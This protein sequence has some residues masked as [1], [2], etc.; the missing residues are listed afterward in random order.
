MPDHIEEYLRRIID[1]PDINQWDG[2]YTHL[3]VKDPIRMSMRLLD[4]RGGRDEHDAEDVVAQGGWLVISGASGMGKTT[5]LKWLTFVYAKKYQEDAERLIPLYVDLAPFRSGEFYNHAL[6]YAKKKGLIADDFKGLLKSGK[7]AIFLDGLDLLRGSEDFDPVYEIQNFMF[8]FPRCEFVLSARPGFFEGFKSDCK[9][10]EL[11][12]LSDPKIKEYIG[13][14]LGDGAIAG[15]LINRIYDPTNKR[16]K[17]LCKNPLMLHR[18]IELQKY[19]R[20]ASDRAGI[21]Q[22][23]FEGLIT[24]YQKKGKTLS[25]NEQLMRDVLK[26]LAFSMQKGNTVRLDYGSALDVA[27]SCTSPKRYISVSAEQVLE[28][29]FKL[30]LLH[31]DGDEVRF[32]FHQ[33]FQ[34][35]FAAVK[36]KDIFEQGYDI[37]ESFSQPKWKDTLVFLSEITE[38]PDELFDDVVGASKVFLAAKLTVENLCALL[39]DKVDSRYDLEKEMAL[40][41]FAYAGD[42]AADVPM[43]VF[44]SEDEGMI[45]NVADALKNIDERSVELLEDA[46]HNNDPDVRK[47]VAWTLVNIG[48]GK[49]VELLLNALHDDNPEVRKDVA[50]ALGIIR[51]ERAV[52]PLVDVLDANNPV[53]R[54]VEALELGII[55]DGMAVEELVNMMER[56]TDPLV[57]KDVAWALGIIRDER[58]VEP[59]ARVLRTD[60]DP[61]VRVVAL[62]ALKEIGDD[63]AVEPFIDAIYNDDHPVVRIAAAWALDESGDER[64]AKPLMDVQDDTDSLVRN[65]VALVLGKTVGRLGKLKLLLRALKSSDPTMRIAAAWILGEVGDEKVV[66][67]LVYVLRHD[68]NPLVQKGV[69]WALGKIGDERAA[70]P[71]IEVLY[72]NDS[73]MVRESVA[74]ALGKVG[75]KRAVEP[76]IDALQD[77]RPMVRLIPVSELKSLCRSI[78]KEK[79]KAL[80]ESDNNDV[81]SAAFEILHSIELKEQ[82]KR[83]IFKELKYL[84]RWDDIPGK[85]NNRLLSYLRE[86]RGI[87]WAERAEIRKSNDTTI[88]IFRDGNSAEIRINKTGKKATLELGD[89]G[90]C[91]MNA[92]K[93]KVES[94]YTTPSGVMDAEKMRTDPHLG[95]LVDRLR[96]VPDNSVVVDYGCGRGAFLG[97]MKTL[98]E[99]IRGIH[100]IGVDISR[101][102]R[103]LTR[104]FAE[105]S[106][107]GD[108]LKSCHCMKPDKFFNEN[109]DV[110]HAFFSHVLHEIHLKYLPEILYHLLSKVKVGSRITFLEQRILVEPESDFVTWDADDFDELFSGFAKVSSRL[111]QTGRGYE[112]ISVDVERLNTDV[113]LESMRE[114]CWEVYDHKKARVLKKLRS[115]DLSKE[116]H[117]YQTALLA[118]IESQM[119]EYQKSIELDE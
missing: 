62:W 114:L 80:Y 63:G 86:D 97:V 57:R 92:I 91:D 29:C 56:E 93:K 37:S 45:P 116:E 100:Y 88:S 41:S 22:E 109:V 5:T 90:T 6:R 50:W 82:E 77:D 4:K 47:S 79:L 105:S 39:L 9:V 33:S 32:G 59:L 66:K 115:P 84:L 12:E 99:E 14:Y 53:V 31:K 17:L 8:D 46:L 28:D 11:V 52:E 58:A 27:G 119:Y 98:E 1:D 43:E 104:R 61:L 102:N 48:D 85:D 108:K 30:G 60:G 78:H 65:G 26:E 36:L 35:Y 24:H 75:D 54:I 34:E 64:A 106:V 13:K 68:D 20:M 96:L 81:A 110:D 10:S 101:G 103:F 23:S 72:N 89:G 118:N 113:S 111:Y 74:W 71:L 19:G 38:R 40:E 7:L 21:Y 3:D 94:G 70:K 83:K 95:A 42:M 112:L 44:T 69:A 51:D 117:Q 107:I 25:S 55:E 2:L 16:L 67:P 49:A 73:P 15:A 76:L 18:V 87:V